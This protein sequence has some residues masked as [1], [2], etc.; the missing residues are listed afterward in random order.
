MLGNALITLELS[1]NAL[2]TQAARAGFVLLG[3]F[4]ISFAFIRTSARLM[5]NPRVTWWPGS[6]KTSGGLHIHHLVWGI[7][8]ILICGFLAIAFHLRSPWLEIVAGGFGVGA[9]LTLDEYAL[10]LHLDDVYWSEEGRRSIDAVIVAAVIAGLVL[11]GVRPINAS[12]TSSVLEIAAAILIVLVICAVALIKGRFILGLVGLVFPPLALFAAIRLAK[13]GSPWARWRY[14][15][16]GRRL[17]RATERFARYKARYQR[18][19]DFIGGAPSMSSAP[20][21]DPAEL[22]VVGGTSPGPEPAPSRRSHS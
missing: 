12:S 9:G 17:R 4:L 7:A 13:P 18:W 15:P 6:V 2:H 1:D 20:R 16:E 8:L 14:A 22:P 5:R 21:P 11:V 10:W 3:A 19:Q